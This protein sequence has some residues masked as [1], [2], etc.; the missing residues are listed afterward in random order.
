MHD[1]KRELK[2]ARVELLTLLFVIMLTLAARVWRRQTLQGKRY[3]SFL[4]QNKIRFPEI[5]ISFSIS[6]HCGVRTET[7]N[8]LNGFC[9]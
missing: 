1:L 9:S 3:P 7:M 5:L 8:P 2:L 6:L 4:N